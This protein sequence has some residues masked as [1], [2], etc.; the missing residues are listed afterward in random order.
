MSLTKFSLKKKA[1][2]AFLFLNRTQRSLFNDV[3]WKLSLQT[4]AG[5]LGKF[6]SIFIFP[7]HRS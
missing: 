1:M 5:S 7:G 3:L 4:F 6:N 2:C